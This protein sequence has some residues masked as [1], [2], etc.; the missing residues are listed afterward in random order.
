M[1]HVICHTHGQGACAVGRVYDQQ[2]GVTYTTHNP[3]IGDNALAP[4]LCARNSDYPAEALGH[5]DLRLGVSH[6]CAAH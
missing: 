2:V 6:V 1:S 4:P 3:T 5:F